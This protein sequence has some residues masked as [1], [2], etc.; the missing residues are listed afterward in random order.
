MHESFIMITHVALSGGGIKG[1][2][3]LGIL[4]YL[5]IENMIN[6]IRYASGS[7]IGALYCLYI[8]LK[9]PVDF[10]ESEYVDLLKEINNSRYL[11]ID[12][13]SFSKLLQSNG[14]ISVEFMM[15][16]VKKYLKQVYEVDDMTYIELAKRT[17]VNIFINTTCVNNGQRT[18]F[19]LENTPN[20]SVIDSIMASMSVPIMFE[21]VCIDGEYHIDGVISKDLPMDIFVNVP[22]ENIL[23]VLIMPS[24][25][26]KNSVN[27]EKNTEFNFM[28][29]ILICMQI[30]TMNLVHQSGN[31]IANRNEFYLLKLE[32]LPY[33]ESFKFEMGEHD[34]MVKLEQHDVDNLILKGFILMAKH[35]QKRHDVAK[36]T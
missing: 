15:R 20:A 10:I 3:Y 22:K 12:K 6:D 2:A 36:L 19:S 14:F 29:Y 31:K 26:L 33:D 18:I 25:K 4:R 1:M 23:A 30:M 24:D 11:C 17:G 9:T 34:V 21:P 28:N 27:Y 5:Y 35:M 13:T 8:A 7:S 32:D 16:P